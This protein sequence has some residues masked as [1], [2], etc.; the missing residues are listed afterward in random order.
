MWKATV[1]GFVHFR[2]V[3]HVVLDFLGLNHHVERVVTASE[4]PPKQSFQVRVDCYYLAFLQ[5]TAQSLNA[6]SAQA[7]VDNKQ[8]SQV[9]QRDDVVNA[10]IRNFRLS[11][12]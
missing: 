11:K 8:F 7:R 3:S 5:R 4:R 1:A 9:W 6:S 10:L 2:I 12:V